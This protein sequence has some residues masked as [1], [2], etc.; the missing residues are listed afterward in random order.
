MTPPARQERSIWKLWVRERDTHPPVWCPVEL[1][2]DTECRVIDGM[3]M[4]AEKP[5]GEA[6]GEFWYG[7]TGDISVNKY[8]VL[9]E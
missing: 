1:V 4:I 8:K 2:S 3:T 7:P 6:W 9:D 5:P